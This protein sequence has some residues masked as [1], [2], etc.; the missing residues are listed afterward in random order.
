MNNILLII[1]V[2]LNG[3]ADHHKYN[4]TH[5][6]NVDVINNIVLSRGSHIL[7]NKLKGFGITKSYNFALN[8]SHII[9][10]NK[11]KLFNS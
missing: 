4:K 10:L 11:T 1:R 2:C 7:S 3:G 9:L 6:L 8:E 5:N